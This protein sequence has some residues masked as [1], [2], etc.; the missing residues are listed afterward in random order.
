MTDDVT[1]EED[2][3][4]LLDGAKPRGRS[5]T[6]YLKDLAEEIEELDAQL[7]DLQRP[8][9]LNSAP[10]ARA[11]AEQIEALRAEMA[12]SALRLRLE[13]MDPD[14]WKALMA[15]HPPRRDSIGQVVDEDAAGVNTATFYPALARKSIVRPAMTDAR[16][17]KLVKAVSSR[18]WDDLW[19][20]AWRLN[21]GEVDIPFSRAASRTLQSSAPE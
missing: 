5:H 14:E 13:A 8:G 10:G 1:A 3:D 19:S 21:R 11:L 2:V 4:A 16:W 7:V 20:L 6:I 17:A 15:Q 12:K 9:M 18:Q